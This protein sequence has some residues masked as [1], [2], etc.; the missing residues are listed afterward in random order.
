MAA[1]SREFAFVLMTQRGDPYVYGAKPAPHDPNPRS[2]DCSGFTHWGLGTLDVVVPLDASDQHLHCLQH[3]TRIS[4][5]E[6]SHTIG[7]ALF[8][9]GSGHGPSGWHVSTS[10]GTG[11]STI[12]ARGKKWGV[13][14]FPFQGRDWNMGAFLWP[15]LDYSPAAI[16]PRSQGD[17]PPTPAGVNPLQL[18]ALAIALWKQR[19]VIHGQRNDGVTFIRNALRNHWGYIGLPYRGPPNA[20]D[21]FDDATLVFVTKFQAD[22]GL[23]QDGICGPLT[24]GALYP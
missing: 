3:G 24:W 10:L 18:V 7:S 1:T 20:T 16:P 14:V 12:E 23:H 9:A 4:V 11:N 6:A 2:E 22:H 8:A 17:P 21:Y 19:V 5:A 13:N 15:H